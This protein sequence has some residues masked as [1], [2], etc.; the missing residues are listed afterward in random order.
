MTV[1]VAHNRANALEQILSQ[2][3]GTVDLD[4]EA[5]WEDAL[6]LGRVGQKYGV[7]VQFRTLEHIAVRTPEALAQGLRAPKNTFRQRHLYCL[8]DLTL[9]TDA[10]LTELEALAIE[11]GDYILGGQLLREATLVWE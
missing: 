1:H 11:H 9:M 10:L 7:A 6:E 5:G 4:Y 3:T 2:V 8:F